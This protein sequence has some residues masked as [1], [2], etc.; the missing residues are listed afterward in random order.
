MGLEGCFYE[1]LPFSKPSLQVLITLTRNSAGL[2]M[3]RLQTIRLLWPSS[4][5]TDFIVGL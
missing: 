5:S 2:E 4:Q 1:P 3:S